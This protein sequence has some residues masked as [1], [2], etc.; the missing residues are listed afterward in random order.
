MEGLLPTTLSA[1]YCQKL[2]KKQALFSSIK[3][4]YVLSVF[5]GRRAKEEKASQTLSHDLL[6]LDR[7]DMTFNLAGC[8]LIRTESH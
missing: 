6:T 2:G 5:C 8:A 4:M 1:D 7:L 3:E